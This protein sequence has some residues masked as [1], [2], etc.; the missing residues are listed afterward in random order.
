MT[1]LLD[2]GSWVALLDHN[3]A[4]HSDYYHLHY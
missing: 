1:P 4:H 2:T 3:D